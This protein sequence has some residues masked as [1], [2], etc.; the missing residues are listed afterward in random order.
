MNIE[1]KQKPNLQFGNQS[2]K[3]L[4]VGKIY[5]KVSR[6][7]KKKY[8]LE[9]SVIRKPVSEKARNIVEI[10][11]CFIQQIAKSYFNVVYLCII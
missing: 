3:D 6:A 4:I 11:T 10:I 8:F 2:G 1:N 5:C 7:S 9:N